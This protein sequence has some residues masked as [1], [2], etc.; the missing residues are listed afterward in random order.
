MF[1]QR[2]IDTNTHIPIVV[3]L[4]LLHGNLD[5]LANDENSIFG[6]QPITLAM[7]FVDIDQVDGRRIIFQ[8]SKAWTATNSSR[9]MEFE[10]SLP[11]LLLSGES[12]I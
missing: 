9:N 7:L 11:G 10:V 3:L 8:Q 4:E 5:L 12:T 1:E 2:N 6:S